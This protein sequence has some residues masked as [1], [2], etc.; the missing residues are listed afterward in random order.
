MKPS[1]NEVPS[2]GAQ[3]KEPFDALGKE[4]QALHVA[5]DDAA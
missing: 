1:V 2:K 3:P 4:V 5:T